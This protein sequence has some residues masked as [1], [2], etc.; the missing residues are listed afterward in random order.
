[1]DSATELRSADTG[2]LASTELLRLLQISS[3]FSSTSCEAVLGNGT[4]TSR[5]SWEPVT[6]TSAMRAN[7]IARSNG[8]SCTAFSSSKRRRAGGFSSNPV[9]ST[10]S[11]INS[12][13]V[14]LYCCRV[15]TGRFAGEAVFRRGAAE[16]LGA[17]LDSTQKGRR[18]A[19]SIDQAHLAADHIDDLRQVFDSC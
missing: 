11:F 13:L 7:S 4:L 19:V 5:S 10:C 12:I 18:A 1:M 8:A 17:P 6:N 16:N 15:T 3:L 9:T 14:G 2:S